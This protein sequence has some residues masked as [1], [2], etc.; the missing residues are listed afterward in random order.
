MVYLVAEDEKH[1]RKGQ[2]DGKHQGI[3]HGDCPQAKI[4]AGFLGTVDRID[5]AYQR[6]GAAGGRPECG[7]CRDRDYG[8]GGLDPDFG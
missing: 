6:E 8:A 2:Q 7:K 1:Q 5:A 4:V 3:Q